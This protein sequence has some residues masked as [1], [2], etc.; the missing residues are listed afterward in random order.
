MQKIKRSYLDLGLSMT[1]DSDGWILES[2]LIKKGPYPKYK[3][4][5]FKFDL[6][7]IESLTE[8]QRKVYK[9]LLK[10][11]AGKTVTYQ[12]LGEKAGYQ[13]AGRAVGSA[14]A[15]NKLVLFIPCHRVVQ[16]TG[17]LGNYSGFG[18]AKTK[19]AL[20]KFEKKGESI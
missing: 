16:S 3:E 2:S 18:G 12:E 5:E 17:G 8:F 15:S 7:K 13:K 10:V 9:S 1:V 14:M 19:Q 20:L 6:K 4:S 11:P